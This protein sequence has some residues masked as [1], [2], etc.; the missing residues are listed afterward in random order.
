MKTLLHIL[1]RDFGRLFKT[2][3]ALTVVAVMIVLPSLYTWY[4]VLGFWNPYENTGNLTVAVV[5]EDAGASSELTGELKVGDSII[6]SLKEN[7]QLNWEFTDRQTAMDALAAGDIY[8]VFVIP[9]DFTE[10]LLSVTTGNF[11]KPELTYF[12]NEK[13]GPVA[14]KITNAGANVLENTI[15]STFVATV[16]EVISQVLEGLLQESDVL[17]AALSADVLNDVNRTRELIA[18]T[19][20]LLGQISAT[21][22]DLRSNVT[23]AQAGLQESQA[24]LN[25]LSGALD[26]AASDAEVVQIAMDAVMAD[27]S[28]ALDRVHASLSTL[29]NDAAGLDEETRAGLESLLAALD[30]SARA[31]A[32][33]AGQSLTESMSTVSVAADALKLTVHAQQLAVSQAQSSLSQL[34]STL[35]MLD[36]VVTSTSGL[37]STV[38]ADLAK[39]ESAL[40]GATAS[41]VLSTLVTDSGLDLDK[42]SEFLGS[43]TRVETEA[44]YPLNAYGSA[45]AP[46]FMNLTFWIGAFML[47]VVIRVE[48]DEEGIRRMNSA[49]RYLGRLLFLMPIA[50][51]QALVCVF[52]V[53][54]I[55]VEAVNLGAL[56]V[57][58]AI[59]SIAYLSVIYF[60]VMTFRHVGKGLAIVLAFIQI[61]GATGLYPVELTSPFFQ[62]VFKFLPFTYGMEAMREGIFGFYGTQYADAL[63]TL[64]F[65][66][67]LFT[68]LGIALLKPMANINQFFAREAREAGVFNDEAV[69]VRGDGN[70]FERLMRGMTSE[71]IAEVG[72]KAA[73]AE[74]VYNVSV[75]VALIGGILVPVIA[76]AIFVQTAAAKTVVLTAWFV[77]ILAVCITMLSVENWRTHAVQAFNNLV[78]TIPGLPEPSAAA[79]PE[80][81]LAEVPEVVAAEDR[82]KAS[83]EEAAVIEAAAETE[84]APASIVEGA[85]E[86][87]SSPEVE[88][89]P[90]VRPEP[91]S[92][93]EVSA[94]SSPAVTY[95]EPEEV[96]AETPRVHY[97][98][99]YAGYSSIVV[100][101][102]EEDEVRH[103]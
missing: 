25:E 80:V 93:S 62:T 4:N 19:Q 71:E 52:G 70:P 85:P 58:A 50:I 34:T 66:A 39:V 46:L 67:L 10:N 91:S 3:A 61:P 6:E 27:L 40:Q 33:S 28:A 26:A 76:T 29:L 17:N 54:I 69:I 11:T 60:L 14:P 94:E 47:L 64:L 88:A 95:E 18:N 73:R 65:F 84:P 15:N 1:G 21:T 31:L 82:A 101:V 43:P 44:L 51:L 98:A 57:A 99:Q 24:A 32:E 78:G 56:Y 49:Q 75:K 48:P 13:T 38:D 23:L 96:P 102:S 92:A 63:G 45:M 36:N 22:G 35:S 8:A 89:A 59:S 9:E 100:E 20:E 72:A 7:D 103:G 81:A 77:W 16:S 53:R 97:A 68:V 12:V 74:R 90:G 42:V 83:P 37:L 41:S 55:G 30:A 86:E 87:G 79:E 2:P 5:N